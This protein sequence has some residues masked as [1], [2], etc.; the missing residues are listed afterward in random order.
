MQLRKGF[1]W[2]LAAQAFLIACN[3]EPGP[4]ASATI[5]DNGGTVVDPPPPSD[6][7]QPPSDPPRD[8][9]SVI[10]AAP[11]IGATDG[12]FNVGQSGDASYSIGL[13]L[14]AG[15]AGVQPGL[16]LV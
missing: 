6:D 15:T 16:K 13:N 4:K 1:P 14:L 9:D 5:T 3:S 2:I 8:P 10:A 7:T 12:E 11:A